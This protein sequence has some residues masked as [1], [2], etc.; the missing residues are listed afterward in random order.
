MGETENFR[1]QIVANNGESKFGA[2]LQHILDDDSLLQNPEV[3]GV[4]DQEVWGEAVYVD[5]GGF[6]KIPACAIRYT[7]GGTATCMTCRDFSDALQ[8]ASFQQ[9]V[10]NSFKKV[11]DLIG[12]H[13]FMMCRPIQN[14]DD[15]FCILIMK[16]EETFFRI[17]S[18][19]THFRKANHSKYAEYLE[20]TDKCSRCGG[21]GVKRILHCTKTRGY[22][23][24][25]EH[26][27]KCYS[28]T[29]C[30]TCKGNKKVP[31]KTPARIVSPN[32]TRLVIPHLPDPDRPRNRSS[33][34]DN[35]WHLGRFMSDDDLE[36]QKSIWKTIGD[37]FT[38]NLKQLNGENVFCMYTT[39]GSVP[40]LHVRFRLCEPNEKGIVTK[41][42]GYDDDRQPQLWDAHKN[43]YFE[44]LFQRWDE[45]P[46]KL[47]K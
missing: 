23:G 40:W 32:G 12:V 19:I 47:L 33:T 3:K 34:Y 5:G 15:S 24:P 14:E 13:Y 31:R 42:H 38:D 36:A 29:D 17:F 20:D 39:G 35:R 1:F 8:D 44:R 46:R 7:T 11:N 30:S 18:R 37:E 28:V 22:F 9:T 41:C 27:N 10:I 16:T 2:P 21:N 4:D 43:K 6:Y 45:T 25:H 26:K